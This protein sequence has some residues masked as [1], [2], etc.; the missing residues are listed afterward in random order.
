MAGKDTVPTTVLP[1]DAHTP[2]QLQNM[3]TQDT[4]TRMFHKDKEMEKG[5]MVKIHLELERCQGV[6]ALLR[7]P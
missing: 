6:R 2:V 7:A 1:T 5:K 4:V 3:C